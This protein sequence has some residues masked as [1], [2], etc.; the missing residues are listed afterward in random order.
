MGGKVDNFIMRAVEIWNSIPFILLAIVLM[1]AFGTG[2]FN[3]IIVVSLTG[4]M[5]FVRVVRSSVLQVKEMDYISA[6]KVMAIPKFIYNYQAYPSKLYW[7][8]YR[9]VYT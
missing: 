7:S 4:V 2:I 6:A 3:L 5:G 8:N 1:S 9:T